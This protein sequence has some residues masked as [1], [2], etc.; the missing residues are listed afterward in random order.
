M[1][2][3]DFPFFSDLMVGFFSTTQGSTACHPPGRSLLPRVEPPST[4]PYAR[5]CGRASGATR[6]AIPMHGYIVLAPD[7]SRNQ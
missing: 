2:G 3:V 5:W 4:D 7:Y 6:T 1:A